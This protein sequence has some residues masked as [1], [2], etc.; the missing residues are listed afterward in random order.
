MTSII[1]SHRSNQGHENPNSGLKPE[2]HGSFNH[3]AQPG[4]DHEPESLLP[5]KTEFVHPK[6]DINLTPAVEPPL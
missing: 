2:N 1:P 6:N 5:I 3:Q 4:V